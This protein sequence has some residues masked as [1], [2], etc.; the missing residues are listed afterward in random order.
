MRCLIAV[1]L[2]F[3]GL[4]SYS[5]KYTEIRD[6]QFNEITPIWSRV[7]I[8]FSQIIDGVNNGTDYIRNDGPEVIVDN[9]FI[10]V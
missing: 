2:L 4:A 7:V 10:K 5:Q 1:I 8:D 3:G 9:K 6:F